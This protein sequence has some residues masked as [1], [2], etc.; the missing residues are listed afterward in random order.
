M[1]VKSGQKR[2]NAGGFL[3]EVVSVRKA[4]KRELRNKAMNFARALR[5]GFDSEDKV[6]L[7]K[8]DGFNFINI[9]TLGGF[10]KAYPFVC[11]DD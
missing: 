6:V 3:V 2:T 11:Y 9:M 7:Y 10:M 8:E 4:N 1:E 5:D